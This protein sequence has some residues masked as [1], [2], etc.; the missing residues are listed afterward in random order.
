[1][2]SKLFFNLIAELI[3]KAKDTRQKLVTDSLTESSKDALESR[4]TLILLRFFG[5]TSYSHDTLPLTS[6]MVGEILHIC[7]DYD[8]Y[9]FY[10][11]LIC[12]LDSMET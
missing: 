9:Y 2:S 6:Q 12:R 4:V 7:S 10:R 1:M 11:A 5:R 8:D 3:R